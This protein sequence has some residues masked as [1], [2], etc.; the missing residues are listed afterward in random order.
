RWFF[1]IVI[2]TTWSES[3]SRRHGGNWT[4]TYSITR[5][6]DK[7]IRNHI[8]SLC[9]VKDHPLEGLLKRWFEISS[10]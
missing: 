6:I 2:Y 4:S 5:S 8:S 3:N 7:M 9:Y 10:V 1:Q